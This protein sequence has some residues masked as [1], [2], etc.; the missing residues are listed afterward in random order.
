M[1]NLEFVSM[2]TECSYDQVM[3]YDGVSYGDRLLGAFS[4]DTLPHPMYAL[5]GHVSSSHSYTLKVLH[6]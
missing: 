6:E 5:S 3:V 1:I 2:M 4:G